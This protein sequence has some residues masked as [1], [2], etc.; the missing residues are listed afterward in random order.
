MSRPALGLLLTTALFLSLLA[1]G[2][3]SST[4][5]ST[6]NPNSPAP[7]SPS[8]SPSPMPGSSNITG[9][10]VDATTN[11]PSSGTVVVALETGPGDF[12]VVARTTVNAQGNFSFSNVPAGGP[13]AIVVEGVNSQGVLYVPT[14]LVTG[15]GPFSPG[16]ALGPGSNVGTIPL[17]LPSPVSATEIMSGT[18][19]SVNASGAPVPVNVT[20][21]PTTFV[22]DFIF[23]VPNPSNAPVTTSTACTGTATFNCASFNVAVPAQTAYFGVFNSSGTS[24]QPFSSGP[25]YGLIAHAF[26]TGTGQPDCSP[27]T[28]TVVA[29]TT[30]FPGNVMTVA[31]VKFTGCQ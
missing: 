17:H 10:V 13:Y 14:I 6:T 18:V 4:N 27:S 25:V 3:G 23:I 9:Q 26:S 31:G 1:G 20:F 12:S 15:S 19:S 5:Q 30:A 8:P 21:D 7:S 24:F 28:Q 11:Q 2:C 29:P 22:A 16:T